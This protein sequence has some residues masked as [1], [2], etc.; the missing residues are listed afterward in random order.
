MVGLARTRTALTLRRLVATAGAV[1]LVPVVAMAAPVQAQEDDLAPLSMAAQD[2]IDDAYIVVFDT[3]SVRDGAVIRDYFADQVEQSGGTIGHEYG[4]AF[5]GFAATMDDATL[6]QLRQSTYVRY[7]QQDE[8]VAIE[9]QVG[10]QSATDQWGLDRIDQRDLPLDGDYTNPLTGVGVDV[11]I[12]D[13][14]LNSTHVEFS[15]RVLGGRNF[16]DDGGTGNWGDC[17]GH[18]THV[19]GTATGSSYGVAPSTGVV[20]VRVLGCNGSGPNS[21]TIAGLDWILEVFTGPTVVNMSLGGPKDQAVDDAVDALIDAGIVVVAAAGNDNRGQCDDSPSGVPRVIT[22]ASSDRTDRKAGNSNFGSCVDLYAPGVQIRSASHRSNTGTRTISGTS[23]A[24][25]HVAGIAA[26]YLEVN[27]SASVAEVSDAIVSVATPDKIRFNPT[28]TVN[29]LAHSS[30]TADAPSAPLDPPQAVAIAPGSD[31]PN[32]PAQVGTGVFTFE[33]G[34]DNAEGVEYR[35]RIFEY[36]FGTRQWDEI[37]DSDYR[38]TD[39]LRL[40]F[41]STQRELVAW[42]VTARRGDDVGER[43]NVLYMSVG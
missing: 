1:F 38:T 14:G 42:F 4:N 32:S 34:V 23:M 37:F 10:I 26:T 25:P 8:T 35:Y 16:V 41:G 12:V 18:G 36:D 17:Q 9:P 22:V 2:G 43:S 3:D 29:L 24:S 15:G 7:I 30:F 21:A 11:F 40:N 27:P 33:A 19:A 13:T 28:G 5:Y 39:S 20:A 31:S 6:N